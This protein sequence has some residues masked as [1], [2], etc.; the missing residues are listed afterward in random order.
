MLK[1]TR[2]VARL[3]NKSAKRAK[4]PENAGKDMAREKKEAEAF[5]L[6]LETQK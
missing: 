1:T 6:G 2:S 5:P 3:K 4:A